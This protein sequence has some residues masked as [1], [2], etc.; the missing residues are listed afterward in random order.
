MYV[1]VFQTLIH[2]HIL[3]L[4]SKNVEF[5]SISSPKKVHHTSISRNFCRRSSDVSDVDRESETIVLSVL[6]IFADE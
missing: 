5:E 4:E 6:W 1:H 3:I 2:L